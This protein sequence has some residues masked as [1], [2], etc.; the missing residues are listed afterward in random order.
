MRLLLVLKGAHEIASLCSFCVKTKDRINVIL[1]I[2][3]QMAI[4]PAHEN[5]IL[6]AS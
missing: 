5:T 4:I 2:F 6:P 3:L 1:K